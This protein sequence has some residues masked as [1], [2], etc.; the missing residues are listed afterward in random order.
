MVKSQMFYGPAEPDSEQIG[1]A[2]HASWTTIEHMRIDH[3][4][5]HIAVT[6]KLLDGSDVGTALERVGGESVA[7]G[8]A[9][10]R[11]ADPGSSDR[12]ANRPLNDRGVEMMPPLFTHL[13]IAP[14]RDLR[15]HPLPN[16]FARG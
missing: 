2:R 7:K 11:F 1:R 14:T 16:P 4:C 3:R 15:E 12:G 10:G 8:V 13:S 9:V 6:K 5:L